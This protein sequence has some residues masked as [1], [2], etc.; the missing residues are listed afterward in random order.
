MINLAKE[1]GVDEVSIT[2]EKGVIVHSNIADAYGFDINTNEFTKPFIQAVANKNFELAS[3]PTIRDFDGKLFQYIG[4]SRLDE[5]GTILIGLEAS[6]VK[7]LSDKF[8]IQE[9]VN[10]VN[11]GE[12]GY[13]YITGKDGRVIAH[14]NTDSVGVNIAD[15]DWGK[16]ILEKGEGTTKYIFNGVEI[17]AH[18]EKEGDM[19][20]VSTFLTNE[21]M[22]NINELRNNT[23]MILVIAIMILVVIISILV[24]GILIK[25]LNVAV[26]QAEKMSNGDFTSETNGK[27]LA[28]KDEIG[29]LANVLDKMKINL[30]D[31]INEISA[32]S[33]NMNTSSQEL[34]ATVEE[35]L[36]QTE[37]ANHTTEEMAANMEESSAAVQQV[38]VSLEEIE[39]S[40]R[41]LAESSENGSQRVAEIANRAMRMKENAEKSSETANNIYRDKVTLIKSS[42]E[43]T[44]VVSDIQKMSWVISEIAEQTNLLALNA[45][46]EAARAGEEGKG[47]AVV[48]DE[49]RK[50][51]EES[52]QA[53][54]S[55]QSTTL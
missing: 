31:V 23:I 45:A 38:S 32:S 39:N 55:I 14:K 50:L 17:F 24:R 44:K 29:L 19:I 28:K 37:T 53:V 18:F 47:F 51:A 35:I 54:A 9:V 25:P 43:K 49:V 13:V 15:F 52:R 7:E 1:I 26:E 20:I 2:D 4:V 30:R 27:F 16:E 36:A 48:A 6:G 41:Q 12:K 46:I 40:T 33:N 21:F 8:D 10:D 34:S 11:I 42:I 5:A 22:N 3:E